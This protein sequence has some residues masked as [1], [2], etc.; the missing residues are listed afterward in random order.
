MVQPPCLAPLCLHLSVRLRF[1]L[2]SETN[3]GRLTNHVFRNNG[4]NLVNSV[5]EG[6]VVSVSRILGRTQSI[7]ADGVL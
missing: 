3:Q 1:L 6:Q 5:R 7:R 2:P 4:F